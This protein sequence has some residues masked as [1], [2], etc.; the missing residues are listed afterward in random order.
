[1]RKLGLVAGLAVGLAVFGARSLMWRSFQPEGA[2][3]GAEMQGSPSS[4]GQY[5]WRSAP[6]WGLKGVE[7]IAVSAPITT[8]AR[9]EVGQEMASQ[10][11]KELMKQSPNAELVESRA[12]AL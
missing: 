3:C 9:G 8:A 10:I 12:S 5:A 4:Q 7:Y 2:G 1:M 6:L 11:M